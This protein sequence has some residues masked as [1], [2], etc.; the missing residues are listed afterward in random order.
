MRNIWVYSVYRNRDDALMALDVTA[1][2]AMEIMGLKRPASFYHFMSINGGKGKFWTVI[3]ER[4]EKVEREMRGGGKG[5]C[6]N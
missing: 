1:A 5:Q 2:E 3:K 6:G 4:A